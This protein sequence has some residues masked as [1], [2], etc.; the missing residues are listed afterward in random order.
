M[1]RRW[2]HGKYVPELVQS[3]R[4]VYLSAWVVS[5]FLITCKNDVS[6]TIFLV[7]FTQ[8]MFKPVNHNEQSEVYDV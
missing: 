2:Q 6:F 3:F 1:D 5:W 7:P 8:I 4:V